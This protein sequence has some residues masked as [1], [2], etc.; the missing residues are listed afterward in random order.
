MKKSLFVGTYTQ[1]LP[2]VNG[3]GRGF[4]RCQW[5][6]RAV[7][8]VQT[9]TGIENPS[10]LTLSPN[11]KNLYVAQET[12]AVDSSAVFA[13]QIEPETSEATY[14]NHVSSQGIAPCHLAVDRT[15]RFLFVANYGGGNVVVYPL[16]ENGRIH[17]PSQIIQHQGSGPN[18]A[19]QEAPH[20]HMVL[21]SPDNQFLIV[22]DLGVD[23][24]FVYRFDEQN[25]HLTLYDEF[26]AVSPGAGPRHAVFGE[27]GRYLFICNELDSTLTVCRFEE[28]KLNHLQTLSTL[29][30][31]WD[32]DSFCAAVKVGGNGR[33]I[34]VSNRGHNSIATFALEP[35][36]EQLTLVAHTSTEGQTPRD[37]TVFD[38]I[39]L[40]GNQDSNSITHFDIDTRTGVPQF[41][42]QISEIPTPV[43][44]VS[45]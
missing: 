19:R 35:Q 39:M 8:V 10:Y 31:G 23:A 18:Q 45:Q 12:G 26:Q 34:Y 2:H 14:L 27:Y 37:F 6:G 16:G 28:G 15:N 4:Y 25:G 3:Q 40:I 24:V 13:Y 11:K 41:T 44:L 1:K 33:F 7:A 32:G 42:G 38:N 20:A 9:V 43:C 30:E 5:D 22:A 21:P 36:T 29:P 17:P